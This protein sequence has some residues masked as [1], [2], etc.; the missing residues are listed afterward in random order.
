MNL[1]IMS[2]AEM[3]DEVSCLKGDLARVV[4]VLKIICK[5]CFLVRFTA[6]ESDR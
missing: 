5:R 1:L 6:A 2:Q 3:Q 4:I